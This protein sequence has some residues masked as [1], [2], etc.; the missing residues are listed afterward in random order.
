ME[1]TYEGW[2]NYAT[3]NASL[4]INN[5]FGIY[6]SA[7]DFMKDVNPQE[8]IYKKFIISQGFENMSTPDDIDWLDDSLDYAELDEMMKELV[9]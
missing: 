6:T 8:D 2:K 7:L 5:D 1:K 3:W 9:A 4:W